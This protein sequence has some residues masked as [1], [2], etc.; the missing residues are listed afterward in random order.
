M[1][2]PSVN[3]QLPYQRHVF[4]LPNANPSAPLYTGQDLAHRVRVLKT[5]GKVTTRLIDERICVET[6]DNN[7]LKTML[8]KKELEVIERK[9]G[10]TKSALGFLSFGVILVALGV[11]GFPPKSDD[12][13][14][15]IA[16]ICGASCV[17]I[18]AICYGVSGQV[19]EHLARTIT[20]LK[21]DPALAIAEARD[22]LY[23]GGF[24]AAFRQKSNPDLPSSTILQQEEI[25]SLYEKEI[26]E[27]AQ[28]AAVNLQRTTLSDE[29]FQ[30]WAIDF[31]RWPYTHTEWIN[32]AYSPEDSRRLVLLDRAAKINA[33]HQDLQ[34][35]A[36]PF[37]EKMKQYERDA[38]R[39]I[40][41]INEMEKTCLRPLEQR[42]ETQKQD[43]EAAC[44]RELNV[45]GL[46]NNRIYEIKQKY[47]GIIQQAQTSYD[48]DKEPIVKAYEKQRMTVISEKTEKCK[49]LAAEA[50]QKAKPLLVQSWSDVLFFKQGI[51]ASV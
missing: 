5:E 21:Q 22:A 23:K 10:Y 27:F 46:S 9:Q 51:D 36:V 35:I 12:I 41:D 16:G 19:P 24:A 43:A 1:S 45:Q 40:E 8:Q 4:R 6:P 26:A 14:P 11:F 31:Q 25:S 34:A 48:K 39:H 37:R 50:L 7:T 38:N 20:Q 33:L 30:Q 49:E 44:N 15:I 42:L 13:R 17:G 2:I 32:Y 47:N 29:E 3:T 18:S 28:K